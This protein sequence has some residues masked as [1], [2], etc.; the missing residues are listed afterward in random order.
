MAELACG[1]VDAAPFRAQLRF[2]TAIGS[3]S[4]ADVATLAGISRAAAEHLLYGRAGR[5]VRRISPDMARRLLAVSADDVRGLPWRLVPVEKAQAQ[6]AR[7]RRSGR[8]DGQIAELAGVSAIELAALDRADRHCSQ[9]LTL[10]LTA[11]ARNEPG[12]LPQRRR[13][14]LPAAA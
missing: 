11:T 10:R 5:P 4:P 2:L 12:Q 6:L 7:L 14:A 9:L 3:L 1:W 13:A 8:S